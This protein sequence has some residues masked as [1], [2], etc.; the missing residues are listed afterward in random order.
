MCHTASC[1]VVFLGGLFMYLWAWHRGLHP[2]ARLLTAVLFND[3]EKIEAGHV[4]FPGSIPDGSW[5]QT[6]PATLR[7]DCGEPWERPGDPENWNNGSC[8][9]DFAACNTFTLDAFGVHGE[10]TMRADWR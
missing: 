2:I 9:I 3:R 6:W 5:D 10:T 1:A 4:C 8:N 7:F